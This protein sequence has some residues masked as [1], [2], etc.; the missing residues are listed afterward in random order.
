MHKGV[1]DGDS[2]QDLESELNLAHTMEEVAQV[3]SM[4]VDSDPENA[5]I[6]IKK[7]KEPFSERILPR[8]HFFC[9]SGESTKRKF[10]CLICFR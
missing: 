10:R 5:C 2:P 1:E 4:H 9:Y 3:E 6:I 8:S 7:E